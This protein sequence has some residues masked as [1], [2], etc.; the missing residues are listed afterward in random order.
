VVGLLG[1]ELLLGYLVLC[2]VQRHFVVEVVLEVELVRFVRLV[3]DLR[4]VVGLVQSLL[5]LCLFDG[6]VLLVE[7]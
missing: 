6:L 2:F 5:K 7:F 4:F 1:L 3:G